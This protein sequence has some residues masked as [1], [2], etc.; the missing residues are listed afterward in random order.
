VDDLLLMF[1]GSLVQD[2]VNIRELLSTAIRGP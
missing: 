1:D 2:G